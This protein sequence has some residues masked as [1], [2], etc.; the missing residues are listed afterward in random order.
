MKSLLSLSKVMVLGMV[1]DKTAVFFML[2]FPL[3]FLVLFG[4]LFQNDQTARVSLTQVGDVEVLDQLDDDQLSDWNDV[5]R[6]EKSGDRDQALEDVRNGDTDA[7]IWEEDGQ[8]QLSVSAADPARSGTATGLINSLVQEANVAATGQEPAYQLATSQVEDESV[9]PIQFFTPGLLGWA[10]AMGAAFM[11]ALTLVGW[12]KN[13]VLRRLWL[14]PI[15]PSSVI[16]ARIGV[17]LGLAFLQLVVFLAIA[18]IPFYGLKLSGN[19]WLSIPLVAAGTL[20][21]MSVGLVIGAW[22]KTEEAA[23]GV[24][25][26]T[27][28]PMAFLSGSFFP[29]DDI[30][31]WLQMVSNVL[32]LK[33]LNE[34]MMS[35]MSRGGGWSDALPTIGGLLLFATVLTLIASRIFRWDNA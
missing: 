26:V 30:P 33:H 1:R 11:S 4:A 15:N 22:T 10:V 16:Y 21:F 7:A 34:A 24:L 9:K 2:I 29:T 17:S 25:Q 28:L 14:A 12:R 8:V 19:W 5:L 23:N 31:G 32:P 27:I 3:M 35:V 20:A 13:R 6:I 18:T